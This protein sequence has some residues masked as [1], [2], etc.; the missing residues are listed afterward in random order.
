MGQGSTE[1]IGRKLSWYLSAFMTQNCPNSCAQYQGYL[2]TA[3]GSVPDAD[4]ISTTQAS[5]SGSRK[6]GSLRDSSILSMRSSNHMATGGV[7]RSWWA[8]LPALPL[9]YRAQHSTRTKGQIL[10][11][12]LTRNSLLSL[13][14]ALCSLTVHRLQL[15]GR[16]EALVTT[17]E[18]KRQVTRNLHTLLTELVLN[19]LWKPYY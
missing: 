6:G 18:L 14:D 8:C 11:H 10:H 13:S 3:K 19:P 5:T 7:E 1:T 4:I 9:T 2:Q 15:S 17:M 16:Y 12:V